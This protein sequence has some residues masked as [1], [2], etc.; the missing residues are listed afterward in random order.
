MAKNSDQYIDKIVQQIAKCDDIVKDLKDGRAAE[1]KIRSQSLAMLKA[2]QSETQSKTGSSAGATSAA[3][4]S[5]KEKE[6]TV[7][8]TKTDK[9]DAGNEKLEKELK[10][11]LQNLTAL[12][13]KFEQYVNSDKTLAKEAVQ[14]AK[15][16]IAEVR[17]Y[18]SGGMK[19]AA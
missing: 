17:N 5:P 7:T 2:M 1:L 6:Y 19:A 9:L 13:N 11:G 14:A 10:A 4:P 3:P 12:V 16:C 18:I 8:E 15:G